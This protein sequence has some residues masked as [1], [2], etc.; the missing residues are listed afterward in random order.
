M[1]KDKIHMY[2]FILTHVTEENVLDLR[3]YIRL[4]S[5]IGANVENKK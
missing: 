1:D 4:H 2:M 3:F 5:L